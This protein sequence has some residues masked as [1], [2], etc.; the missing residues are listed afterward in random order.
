MTASTPSN[1]YEDRIAAA[2]AAFVEAA[3]AAAADADRIYRLPDGQNH[4]AAISRIDQATAGLLRLR[5][6]MGTWPPEAGPLVAEFRRGV[7]APFAMLADLRR[8]MLQ[9]LAEWRAANEWR[10]GRG[11]ETADDEIGS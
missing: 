6:E 1:V 4:L 7:E 5:D 9:R 3:T 2:A 11:G 8:E 10:H